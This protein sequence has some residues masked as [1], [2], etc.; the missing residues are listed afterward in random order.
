[1]D[2]VKPFASEFNFTTTVEIPL[3]TTSLHFNLP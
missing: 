3:K 2:N 1:M